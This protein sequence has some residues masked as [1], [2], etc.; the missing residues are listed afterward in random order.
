MH[1]AWAQDKKAD[2]DCWDLE[3]GERIYGHITQY[4]GSE[5]YCWQAVR[6]DFRLAGIEVGREAAANLA[7]ETLALPVDEFNRRVTVE[8]IDDLRKIE[9]DILRLSP[10]AEILPGYH[11]GYE[12]GASDVR[13]RIAEALDEGHNANF[14]GSTPLYGDES[15]GKTGSTT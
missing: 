5:R 2:T 9:R 11:A 14:S 15:A 3:I 6:G 12:A 1:D 8:L 7:E 13:R 4:A 10:A